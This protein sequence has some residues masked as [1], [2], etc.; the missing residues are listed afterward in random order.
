MTATKTLRDTFLASHTAGGNTSPLKTTAWE[1]SS[2]QG[3]FTRGNDPCNLRHNGATK[4][5]D[6]KQEKLPSVTAPPG[7]PVFRPPQEP[8]FPNSKGK[9]HSVDSTEIPIYLFIIYLLFIFSFVCLSESIISLLLKV[10]VGCS[11][12]Y[13]HSQHK[14]QPVN[15]RNS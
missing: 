11:P 2:F 5:R 13:F 4:L 6:K 14:H 10:L 15:S 8:T 7:T 3:M 12:V 9:S 1:A